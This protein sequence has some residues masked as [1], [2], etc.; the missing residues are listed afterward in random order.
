VQATPPSVPAAR[1]YLAR[2]HDVV[3]MQ[4]N[5]T[6]VRKNGYALYF[7]VVWR[8][9]RSAF[10]VKLCEDRRGHVI[11]SSNISNGEPSC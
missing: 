6:Q 7:T 3:L 10:V 1:A 4:F 5:G 2:A 11:G 9:A 8:G